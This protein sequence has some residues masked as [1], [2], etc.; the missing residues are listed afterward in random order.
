MSQEAALDQY[1]NRDDI[2]YAIAEQYGPLFRNVIFNSYLKGGN[3]AS[4]FLRSVSELKSGAELDTMLQSR[5]YFVSGSAAHKNFAIWVKRWFLNVKEIKEFVNALFSLL[6]WCL[7]QEGNFD[8]VLVDVEIGSSII[9]SAAELC[10]RFGDGGDERIDSILAEFATQCKRTH[11]QDVIRNMWAKDLYPNWTTPTELYMESHGQFLQSVF[12]T[13]G[14]LVSNIYR[15]ICATERLVK[16]GAGIHSDLETGIRGPFS[17]SL[18]STLQITEPLLKPQQITRYYDIKEGDGALQHFVNLLF[19]PTTAETRPLKLRFKYTLYLAGYSDYF[20]LNLN[21]LSSDFP[22]SDFGRSV[23]F[24]A[25]WKTHPGS[26]H[27]RVPLET[28][29]ELLKITTLAIPATDRV[30]RGQSLPRIVRLAPTLNQR[31]RPQTESAPAVIN[32]TRNK[33]RRRSPLTSENEE[34]LAE[35]PDAKRTRG[36]TVSP[37]PDEEPVATTTENKNQYVVVLAA[38]G[39]LTLGAVVYTKGRA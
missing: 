20:Y 9:Q 12:S 39:V 34:K 5:H 3:P 19:Y 32:I 18:A 17:E 11:V 6:D 15:T 2:F 1:F 33:K 37:T 7:E 23:D 14:G 8:E 36:G 29:K 25:Y 10:F 30:I 35:A 38:I 13:E 16:H 31:P 26:S 24:P 22:G 21:L 4:Q 27:N 28:W